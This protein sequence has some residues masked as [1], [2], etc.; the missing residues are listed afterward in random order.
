[1]R[2]NNID[3][4]LLDKIDDGILDDVSIDKLQCILNIYPRE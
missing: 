4:H 2:A 1:M 3:L